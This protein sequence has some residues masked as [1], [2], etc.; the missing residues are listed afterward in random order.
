MNYH[1][2]C[3]Y[4]YPI[5]IIT[6]TAIII[7]FKSSCSVVFFF[8]PMIIIPPSVFSKIINSPAF[9]FCTL[10]KFASNSK[11]QIVSFL[12]TF[13]FNISSLVLTVIST[14]ITLAIIH[15]IF[16]TTTFLSINIHYTVFVIPRIYNIK[17]KLKIN[18]IMII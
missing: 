7:L 2:N 6:T 12:V 18:N 15:T 16:F 13:Y 8:S 1:Y 9:I 17:I 10:V 11:T 14:P 4:V 5:I 3:H